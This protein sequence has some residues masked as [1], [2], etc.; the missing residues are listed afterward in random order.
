MADLDLNKDY[1]FYVTG[2]NPLE[3]PPSET[4]TYRVGGRPSKCGAISEIVESRTGSRLGLQWE[5]SI[6]DGGSP[7]YVYTLA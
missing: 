2:L 7:I 5:D 3:G 1:T 4:V 6:S